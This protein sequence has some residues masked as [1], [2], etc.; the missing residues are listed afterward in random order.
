VASSSV[1]PREGDRVRGPHEKRWVVRA[2]DGTSL[3]DVLA[4]MREDAAAAVAAGRVF[5][6]RKRVTDPD[7]RIAPGDEIRV[8]AASVRAAN[9][10]PAAR[11][12]VTILHRGD[13]L[14]AALKPSGMVTVPDHAGAAHSFVEAV[15]RAAGVESSS[16]RVTSRLDREVS[17]VIVLATDD[18]SE[19]RLR[20]ARER[21]TYVRRYVAI[22]A[23]MDAS[24]L[25]DAGAWIAPIGRGKDARHRAVNGVDAKEARTLY[26]VV[27]RTHGGCFALLAV[28][29]I[30]GRTHQI[31]VHAASAGAPLF[32]D[33]DYGGPVRATLESGRIVSLGRIA[34]HAAEV[35]VPT[36]AGAVLAI[37]APVPPE[38]A[39]AW[40]ELGGDAEAWNRAVSCEIE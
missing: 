9:V 31:R 16:L 25:T 2:G 21:G 17:G 4:K 7:A 33:R 8:G 39:G 11:A 38:L 18:G 27:A 24:E 15:A 10:T 19:A 34:L 1:F 20:E 14:I 36:D 30:T 35:R 6:G 40:A 5:V 3:R 23:T 26:R 37:A 32:G 22:A 12:E 29:P 28:A 13:G